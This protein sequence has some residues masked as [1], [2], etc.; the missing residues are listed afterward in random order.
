[1]AQLNI[2]GAGAWG[3]ALGTAAFRAGNNVKLWTI[4]APSVEAIN[5]QHTN[6]FLPEVPLPEALVA[7][8]DLEESVQADALLLVVPAQVLSS[9]CQQMKAT[10]LAKETPL[11]LCNK[12]IEQGSLKLMSEIVA[13]HFPENPIAV[14]SGPNFADEVARGEPAATTLA[15]A[16]EK[17]S[18]KLMALMGSKL[19]RTYHS[20]D[21]I[22]AQ[23]GGS[24]KNV[25]AIACGISQGKGFGENTK[26][27]LVS[28]GIVEMTRLC[29]AKGGKTKTLLGLCGIG[30]MMLTCGTTKSRN[31][32]FGYQLGQGTDLNTVLSQGKT[33]EGVPTAKSIHMLA[34]QLG[35]DMP[36]C[37]AVYRII[38]ENA[39]IDETIEWL[40]SRPLT[41]ELQ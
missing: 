10:S 19:F 32:S 16:D 22:G 11:I 20:P 39:D 31:M 26:V 35:V 17:V 40:L 37:E 21:I 8:T 13:E 25:I 27:A 28:R 5:S 30:D 41:E 12:G 29:K 24:V 23:I 14:I 34:Q 36:I 9:V 6:P 1:M 3:T 7:T 15:C 2:I 33:V 38:H 4:D 18:K